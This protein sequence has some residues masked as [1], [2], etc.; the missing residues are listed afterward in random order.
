MDAET[1]II[2]S[3]RDISPDIFGLLSVEMG[4]TSTEKIFDKVS[5]HGLPDGNYPPTR[6]GR[7]IGYKV[8]FGSADEG[9]PLTSVYLRRLINVDLSK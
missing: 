9:K 6:F 8:Q 2:V 3:L 1:L 5:L 7:C 4:A